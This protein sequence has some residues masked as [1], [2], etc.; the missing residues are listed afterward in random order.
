MYEDRFGYDPKV[1]EDI[2]LIFM[3][4]CQDVS[5]LQ[6]EWDFYLDLFDK[7]ENNELF[8]EVAPMS[9]D[10]IEEVLRHDMIMSIGRLSDPKISIKKKENL[11][12]AA[13]VE[14]CADIHGLELLLEKFQLSCL[15][16]TQWRNKR[17]GHRDLYTTISPS[18]HPLPKIDKQQLDQILSEASEILKAVFLHYSRGDLYFHTIAPGKADDLI[19]YLKSGRDFTRKNG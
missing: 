15:H 3:W 10:I 17:V 11:S 12:L 19:F 16:T 2:R 14:R 9:F 5:S 13:L 18:E 8:H 6:N 7:E 4:L 1:P